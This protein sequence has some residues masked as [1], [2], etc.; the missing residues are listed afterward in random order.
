MDGRPSMAASTA[1][2]VHKTTRQYYFPMSQFR[3]KALL[4]TCLGLVHNHLDLQSVYAPRYESMLMRCCVIVSE[5]L[6]RYESWRE[7]MVNL[8]ES[9]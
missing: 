9:G 2:N 4:A 1:N 6:R 5:E 3:S 7:S 8:L